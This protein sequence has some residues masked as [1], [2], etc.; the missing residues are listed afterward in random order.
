MRHYRIVAL[1]VALGAALSIPAVGATAPGDQ[2]K[3]SAC[4]DITLWN[5]DQSGPPQY[6]THLAGGATGP[7]TV[8]ASITTAK[9][10][11]S[12]FTYTVTVYSD[13]T[14]QTTLD[15][16]TVN[17]DGSTG[18]LQYTYSPAGAPAQVCIAAT[19]MRDGHVVDAAPDSGCAILVLDGG[20]G[21]ASGLN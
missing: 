18:P 17:G 5:G 21:G 1:L 7:A 4:G 9:P 12:N 3:G 2:V 16:K 15:F 11:C 10:S 14:Q 13:A 20:S 8:Y 19:S 6:T